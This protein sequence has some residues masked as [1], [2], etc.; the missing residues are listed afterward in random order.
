MKIRLAGYTLIEVLLVVSIMAVLVG[1]A[2]TY[3]IN[4][5][6][7]RVAQLD[8]EKYYLKAKNILLHTRNLHAQGFRSPTDLDIE[9][10]KTATQN[11]KWKAIV[12][13]ISAITDGHAPGDFK[14]RI[15]EGDIQVKFLIADDIVLNSYPLRKNPLAGA[16]DEAIL[17]EA[18]HP[19]R[20]RIL[21]LNN[22]LAN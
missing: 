5:S 21:R 11:E 9:Q 8:F 2:A 19:E 3:N 1:I 17:S 18:I 6:T 15:N 22:Y 10:L 4:T 14:I 16:K 7:Q 12:N 20:S 13:E